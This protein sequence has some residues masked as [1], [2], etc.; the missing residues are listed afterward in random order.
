MDGSL[1]GALESARRPVRVASGG[2]GERKRVAR[3]TKKP[4]EVEES[5]AQQSPVAPTA[6]AAPLYQGGPRYLAP[7]A[8]G[9]PGG[10]G[11]PST[12]AYNV[13]TYGAPVPGY[14]GGATTGKA[15]DPSLPAAAYRGPGGGGR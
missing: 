5:V 12:T 14:G 7:I 9:A 2:G 3:R 6:P 15:L 13:Q 4:A 10:G 8:G 11:A 1:E